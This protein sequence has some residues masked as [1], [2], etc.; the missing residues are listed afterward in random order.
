MSA[1][2]DIASAVFCD[3]DPPVLFI[4][5][6]MPAP[7]PHIRAVLGAQY[8]VAPQQV[9]VVDELP[10]VRTENHQLVVEITDE[11]RPTYLFERPASGSEQHVCALFESV[12]D[13]NEIGVNDHLFEL[14]GTSV[15]VVE[16]ARRLLDEHGT[17][18][19]LVD[20]LDNLT[21]RAVAAQMD[22]VR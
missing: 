14:G 2:E 6:E 22:R 16:I 13:I 8:G 15:D 7:G 5:D 12:L 3:A 10:A 1:L 17:E 9:Y 4:R 21:V 18:L 19:N 11:L 20:L